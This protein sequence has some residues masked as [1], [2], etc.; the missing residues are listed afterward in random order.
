MNYDDIKKMV[1]LVEA[2]RELSAQSRNR[3]FRK[4][5]ERL[6]SHYHAFLTIGCSTVPILHYA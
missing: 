6:E 1:A 2:C 4:L 5:Y 3:R